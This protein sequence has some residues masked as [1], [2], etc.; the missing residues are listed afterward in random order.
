M[1]I[2]FQFRS[3]SEFCTLIPPNCCMNLGQ[4]FSIFDGLWKQV[5]SSGN[6]QN[7]GPDPTDCVWVRLGWRLN[8]CYLFT[9]FANDSDP[10]EM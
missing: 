9:N 6:T 10:T 3:V 1:G 4:C 8:I 7:P 5:G 2:C